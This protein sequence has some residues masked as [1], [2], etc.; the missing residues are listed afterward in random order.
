MVIISEELDNPKGI[1][2]LWVWDSNCCGV[3]ALM[4]LYL[5]I[6]YIYYY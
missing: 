4:G 5:K 6:S 2:V 3:W 1:V